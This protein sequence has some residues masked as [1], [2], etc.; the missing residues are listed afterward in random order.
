MSRI[1]A[2]LITLN[3]ERHLARA[4]KSL[5][6][7][8]DEMIVVDSGSTDA[9]PQIAQDHGAKFL[10]HPWT[11]YADQKNFAAEQAEND[12][13]LSLDADEEISPR[14]R[15]ALLFW[16]SIE[17]R[18]TVYEFARRT[19]YLGAWIKHSGW[20]PDYQ[21]RLYRRDSAKFEGIIHE[22]LRF[23]GQP[24][25][26]QGD[27]LH[28]TVQSFAE[29]EANVDKYTSLAAKQMFD[30]GKRRWKAAMWLATPWS[31]FQNYI[32][33]GG[34]LDGFR[35]NLISKMAARSVWLKY[36]KLGKLIEREKRLSRRERLKPLIVD[37]ETAWRGGQN[38]ALLM[39]KGL[40][41][42]G[43]E[44]ELVAAN[45]SA[46]GQRAIAK[47]FGVHFVS[48]GLLR[49]PAVLEIR[50]LLR[51][52]R[53][54]LVHANE[55]HAVSA[56][57]LA[58]AH[59]RVP[60]VISRRVGYPIGKSFIARARYHAASR[61]IANSKWVAA[62]AARS[63]APAADIS[64]V[65]EGA[66]IPP[67]FTEDAKREARSRWRISG[68]APLLGC[69]GAMS[70]D[71]GQEWLVRALPE[72][73]K[74]FPEAKL[75][76]AGDGP[77]WPEL[78]ALARELQLQEAV[79]FPGFVKDIDSVYAALDVFLL[80]SFFEAL[81]NSL[82]AAM[83][84]EIPSIAF[85][86]GALGEIIEHEKSGLLVSGPDVAE[87]SNA[88]KRLLRD[89]EFATTLGREG[90]KRVEENFSADRMVEGMLQVYRE[91]LPEP[92]EAKTR[93]PDRRPNLTA[94]QKE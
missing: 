15:K 26:L 79:L 35:G 66:E 81:N 27:L 11:S 37:L 58:R 45:N 86:K 25:L 47:G 60:L 54:D 13:I 48:R 53:F 88:A 82:L 33:R 22:A 1:S 83:A 36:Q 24:G 68:D 71:K 55:A 56:G 62:Q 72:I 43:Y 9:T 49:I 7:I 69:V 67:L 8:A 51:A 74:E 18:R 92:V 42:R 65:Y 78:S 23:D 41:A 80:P 44:A 12:W 46:L 39:L 85:N 87:I 6:G 31:W 32:F 94:T 73:R 63:G 2:C 3:E 61:I 93:A 38:Q 89:R 84:Y 52:G 29:H 64:T 28:Y 20:Y 14:L 40:R 34:F 75:L 30:V 70:P 17:P 5:Q 19:W 10:Q 76:L 16:K 21:R 4:L 90:R 59:K 57:W 50:E 77:C 91:V